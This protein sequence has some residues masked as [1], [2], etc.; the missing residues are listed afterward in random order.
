MKD[1]CALTNPRVATKDQI[2]EIYRQAYEG[3]PSPN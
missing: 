2:I 3:V 1:A